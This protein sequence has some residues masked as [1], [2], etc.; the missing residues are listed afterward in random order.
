MAE[1]YSPEMVEKC[2][3]ILKVK[4]E[5]NRRLQEQG[6]QEDPIEKDKAGIASILS[7]AEPVKDVTPSKGNHPTSEESI[8]SPSVSEIIA[9]RKEESSIYMQPDSDCE[10]ISWF[11][12]IISDEISQVEGEVSQETVFK[13]LL[14]KVF[15]SDNLDDELE[16]K[17]RKFVRQSVK[18]TEP[19][20]IRKGDVITLETDEGTI[21]GAVTAITESSLVVKTEEGK[22]RVNLRVPGAKTIQEHREIEELLQNNDCDDVDDLIDQMLED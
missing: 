18:R 7:G 22:K 8:N 20:V 6:S 14:K 5:N 4:A 9:R 16:G 12:E 1:K 21:V 3:E 19:G 2:N 13:S 15:G 17:V 10:V 11:N